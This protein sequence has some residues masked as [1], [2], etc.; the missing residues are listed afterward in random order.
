MSKIELNTKISNLEKSIRRRQEEIRGLLAEHD[1]VR[2][3]ACDPTAND[4][5]RKNFLK[6]SDDIRRLV[7]TRKDELA[8]A[9]A[10]LRLVRTQV[11]LGVSKQLEELSWNKG[12]AAHTRK[13]ETELA[14]LQAIVT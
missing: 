2:D 12:Q 3:W 13:L 14:R 8:H 9:Q 1:Q 6:S 10:R 7:A 11:A 4:R 5:D